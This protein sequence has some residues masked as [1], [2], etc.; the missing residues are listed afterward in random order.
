MKL[1]QRII[2]WIVSIAVVLS[3]RVEWHDRN[4]KSVG[5]TKGPSATRLLESNEH[6]KSPKAQLLNSNPKKFKMLVAFFGHHYDQP[7][8]VLESRKPR[9]KPSKR[10]GHTS[11]HLNERKLFLWQKGVRILNPVNLHQVGER[12]S[13]SEDHPVDS[14]KCL[15]KQLGLTHIVTY[16]ING[17]PKIQERILKQHLSKEEQEE[18]ADCDDYLFEAS[19]Q[20]IQMQDSENEDA[21]FLDYQEYDDFLDK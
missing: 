5:S 15:T 11:S 4:A 12:N 21:N 16:N 7:P 13:D 9:R 8:V 14:I 10:H 18:L 19:D 17:V 2:I 20:L 6:V 1:M 3:I